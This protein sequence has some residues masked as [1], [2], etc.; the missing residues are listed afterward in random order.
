MI[1][2]RRVS[3]WLRTSHK[4]QTNENRS[5]HLPLP[6]G[7]IAMRD[8]NPLNTRIYTSFLHPMR[9]EQYT[10]CA[11]LKIQMII[12]KKSAIMGQAFLTQLIPN[13]YTYVFVDKKSS[14][15]RCNQNGMI[16]SR[17]QIKLKKKSALYC[18]QNEAILKTKCLLLSMIKDQNVLC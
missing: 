2:R 1:P 7:V 13:T 15:K 14:F 17:N 12:R 18:F 8:R 6:K 5:K 16:F 11:A 4:S 9:V 10:P 3:N